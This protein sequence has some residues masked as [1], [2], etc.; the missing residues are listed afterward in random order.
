M[1]SPCPYS[2]SESIL[3]WGHAASPP[4]RSDLLQ[5]DP[6]SGIPK[7]LVALRA[8]FIPI[9]LYRRYRPF[10][11]DCPAIS[12]DAIAPLHE[13]SRT[14]TE[15]SHHRQVF[16]TPVEAANHPDASDITEES[17]PDIGLKQ[18]R[19]S[20]ILAVHSSYRVYPSP[21]I[22]VSEPTLHLAVVVAP[23]EEQRAGSGP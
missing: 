14:L 1:P 9:A 6:H 22:A 13:A 11:S 16:A 10:P 2:L 18:R 12:V 21:T 8:E 4:G 7:S 5:L 17:Y 15:C 19:Q 3:D 20:P 23:S